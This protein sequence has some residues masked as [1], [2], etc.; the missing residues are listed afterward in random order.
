M[1]S[2]SPGWR[3]AFKRGKDL[4]RVR[5]NA[6]HFV[7]GARTSWHSHGLGQTLCER[8]GFQHFAEPLDSR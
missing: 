3:R 2:W 8:A 7:P 1:S 4:S 6:V 5:A